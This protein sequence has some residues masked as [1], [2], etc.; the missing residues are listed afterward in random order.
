MPRYLFIV[1]RGNPALFDFLRER[2]AD[3]ENVEVILDRRMRAAPSPPA[4]ERRLRP[5]VN[6]EIR[7]SEYSVVSLP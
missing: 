4:V 1:S 7:A 2:F 6:D 3:D 5:E